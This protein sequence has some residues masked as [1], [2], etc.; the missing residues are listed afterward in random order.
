MPNH[1]TLRVPKYQAPGIITEIIIASKVFICFKYIC[2]QWTNF[3]LDE[4]L[5]HT[6]SSSKFERIIFNLFINLMLLIS[7]VS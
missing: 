7:H 3:K 4:S 5:I 6:K 2:S 1:I